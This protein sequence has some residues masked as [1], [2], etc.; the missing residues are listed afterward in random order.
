MKP[1]EFS[2]IGTLPNNFMAK[3]SLEINYEFN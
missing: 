2:Q 3:Q 1:Q